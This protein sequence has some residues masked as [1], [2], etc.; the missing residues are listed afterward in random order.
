MQ[1]TDTISLIWLV[2]FSKKSSSQ[3][4]GREYPLK[5]K[6]KSLF[7]LIF[8]ILIFATDGGNGVPDG[9]HNGK[10]SLASWEVILPVV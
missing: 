7:L 1:F 10:G 8:A 3:G 2:I 9:D 4:S 6:A 5:G